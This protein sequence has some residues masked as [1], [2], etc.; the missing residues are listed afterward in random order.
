MIWN[1]NPMTV[2]QVTLAEIFKIAPDCRGLKTFF[3]SNEGCQ[4]IF[5]TLP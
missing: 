2:T 3:E 4:N 1:L 5:Q